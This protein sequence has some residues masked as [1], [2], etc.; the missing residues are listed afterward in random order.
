MNEILIDIRAILGSQ[1]R[2]ERDATE[3]LQRV[4]AKNAAPGADL[5]T[6]P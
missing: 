2:L 3:S 1:K 5:G 4:D 6:R